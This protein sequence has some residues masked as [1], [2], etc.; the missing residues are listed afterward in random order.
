MSNDKPVMKATNSKEDAGSPVALSAASKP[1]KSVAK[2]AKQLLEDE[3]TPSVSSSASS[4]TLVQDGLTG[5][6]RAIPPSP[7]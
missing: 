7:P 3:T 6:A 5:D 4:V 2:D 1:M